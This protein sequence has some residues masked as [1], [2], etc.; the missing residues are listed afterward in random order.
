MWT[1]PPYEHVKEHVITGCL[2]KCPFCGALCTNDTSDH[3]TH[4]TQHHRPLA[5]K[6]WA[7]RMKGA[8]QVSD[9]FM[10]CTC[11]QLMENDVQFQD[12]SDSPHVV[13]SGECGA[14]YGGW[15]HWRS[16]KF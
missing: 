12:R 13:R 16:Q 4:S 11:D 2:E 15:K 14:E 8:P 10:L 1:K 6:G 9:E 7:C 5:L 3:M